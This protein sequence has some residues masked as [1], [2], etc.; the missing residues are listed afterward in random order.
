MKKN[1]VINYACALLA[2][3][4]L[5]IGAG[6]F[7]INIKAPADAKS[8]EGMDITKAEP[9]EYYSAEFLIVDIYAYYGDSVLHSSEYFCYALVKDKYNNTQAVSLSITEKDSLFKDVKE[10]AC[11]EEAEIGDLVIECAAKAQKISAYPDYINKWYGESAETYN[12]MI[13]ISSSIPTNFEFF[14]SV[15]DFVEMRKAGQ[16]AMLITS[17]ICTVI[18]AAFALAAFLVPGIKVNKAPRLTML[19]S[20]EAAD[21][22]TE[23]TEITENNE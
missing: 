19:Q 6:V 9:I 8:L 1:Y 3:I 14:S 18:G 13:G 12:E 10:Y 20:D 17:M 2:L 11:N 5:I 15:K 22:T 23:T 7:L 4:L 16:K 21:K